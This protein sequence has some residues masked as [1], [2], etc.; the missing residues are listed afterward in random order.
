MQIRG[1]IWGGVVLKGTWD[2]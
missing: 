2:H 1:A